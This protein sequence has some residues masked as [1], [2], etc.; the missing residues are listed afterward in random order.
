MLFHH[1]KEG[2]LVIFN[3]TDRLQEHYTMV[4]CYT[5]PEVKGRQAREGGAPLAVRGLGT[6]EGL[7]GGH[8]VDTPRVS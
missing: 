7:F 6:W 3:N 4:E 2:N 8:R 1:Y 5:A